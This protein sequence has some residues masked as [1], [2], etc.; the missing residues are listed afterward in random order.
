MQEKKGLER[1][2]PVP[3]PRGGARALPEESRVRYA[4]VYAERLRKSSSRYSLPPSCSRA[5]SSLLMHPN[6]LWN[7]G[8][9]RALFPLG[10][11]SRRNRY[12]AKYGA[13]AR[14]RPKALRSVAWV[15]VSCTA[16]AKRC[17]M[18]ERSSWVKGSI[19]LPVYTEAGKAGT[20]Q[21]SVTHVAGVSLN[22]LIFPSHSRNPKHENVPGIC[23]W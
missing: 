9:S 23:T 20:A 1:A 4:S 7:Q 13:P 14:Y 17:R 21:K 8:V 2:G 12:C 10:G 16:V 18:Q 3:R 5:P 11:M 19:G 15:R 22:K 6:S